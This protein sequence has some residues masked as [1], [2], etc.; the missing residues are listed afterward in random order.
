VTVVKVQNVVLYVTI[1]CDVS[2][3]GW[4]YQFSPSPPNWGIPD[5]PVQG[6]GGYEPPGGGDPYYDPCNPPGPDTIRVPPECNDP[7]NWIDPSLVWLCEEPC[8]TGNPVI[9]D[10]QIQQAFTQLWEESLTTLP[11]NQ[12]REQGGWVISTSNG[13]E[14]EPFPSGWTGYP[15]GIA[16]PTNWYEFAPSNTVG[17][18][19]THPFFEGEDTTALD[20]CGPE[21]DGTEDWNSVYSDEDYDALV[22]LANHL[23]NY[24]IKGYVIDGDNILTYSVLNHP[25]FGPESSHD[26]CG[27]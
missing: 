19:H 26:R 12:R 21:P 3:S 17:M 14:F 6:G 27:Y 5:P 24:S 15:C 11:I 4:D 7:C 2:G 18:V 20:V 10:I 9:D 13:Y 1:E 16:A 23:D 22:D 8:S 25:S